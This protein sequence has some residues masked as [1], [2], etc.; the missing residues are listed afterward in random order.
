MTRGSSSGPVRIQRGDS[1]K[2]KLRN[3]ILS[4]ESERDIPVTDM[5]EWLKQ[6]MMAEGTR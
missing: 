6:I 2:D 3:G 1:L 5:A 4:E